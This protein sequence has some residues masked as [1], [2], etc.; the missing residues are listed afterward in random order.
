[1]R[2]CQERLAFAIRNTCGFQA[3]TERVLQIMDA[4]S[5]KSRRRRLVLERSPF[6]C[7]SLPSQAPR[8]LQH[9]LHR[10]PADYR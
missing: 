2:M 4:K 8:L 3:M 1:M 6:F 7:G 5:R 10:S 9:P